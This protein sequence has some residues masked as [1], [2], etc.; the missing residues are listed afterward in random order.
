MTEQYAQTNINNPRL[1]RSFVAAFP[2]IPVQLNFDDGF[3]VADTT[4]ASMGFT[5]PLASQFPGWP[6]ILKATNA[7]TS[8]NP[9]FVS[10]QD[11]ETI[12]GAPF[13][14][15]TEDQESLFLKSDGENWRVV[16][17]SSGLVTTTFSLDLTYDS[18]AFAS[19]SPVLFTTWPEILAA[20]ALIPGGLISG[21]PY[22]TRYRLNIATLS[23]IDPGIHDLNNAE[24]RSARGFVVLPF[25]GLFVID[26]VARLERIFA[27]AF[28]AASTF[29]WSTG[30][31]VEIDDCSFTQ[32]TDGVGPPIVQS[33]ATNF[34]IVS[35]GNTIFGAFSL[36]VS[37]VPGDTLTIDAY[38][39]FF[40]TSSAAG[41]AGDLVI[42]ILS[43]AT[44]VSLIQAVGLL[45]LHIGGISSGLPYTL[46]E[47]MLFSSGGPIDFSVATEAQLYAGGTNPPGAP[48]QV[49][50]GAAP[51]R[52]ME[53]SRDGYLRGIAV[54]IPTT[55]AAP[56]LSFAITVYVSGVPTLVETFTTSSIG[57]YD[58]IT[59]GR[60]DEGDSLRVTITPLTTA[61][62]ATLPDGIVVTLR[63]A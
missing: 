57:A 35:T 26:N 27:I 14:L 45:D 3:V 25:S 4:V 11:G 8:G 47:N 63:S 2:A 62:G 19:V 54:R 61:P 15:L 32:L 29:T 7:A 9:V 13:A 55:F 40:M 21:T 30:G 31:T 49:P 20:V 42:N 34:R 22:T 23:T 39:G 6:I 33:P 28:S 44:N 18:A 43:G 24:F 1:V 58:D 36:G 51:F 48:P 41:G 52:S 17:G 12:D 38:D 37:P 60:F 53:P 46:G 59:F 5:L 16:T 50:T 10:T 56:A